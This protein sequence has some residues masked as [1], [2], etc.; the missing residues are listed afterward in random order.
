MFSECLESWLEDRGLHE[1][2]VAGYVEEECR[3][4]LTCGIV[5]F[6][7][8][9]AA[10]TWCRRPHTWSIT[11]SRPHP[12]AVGDFRA[13]A[14]ARVSRRPARGG[15]GGH[16]GHEGHDHHAGCCDS[17][18]QPRSHDTSRIAWA[19]ADLPLVERRD[20]RLEEGGKGVGERSR[21]LGRILAPATRRLPPP[22]RRYT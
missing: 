16:E 20:G 22:S 15:R 13:E 10:G 11:S 3:G 8:A 18:D 9:R 21:S 12:S 4:Y 2:P 6:G 17:A 19:R 7:F 5:C 1:R 14:I